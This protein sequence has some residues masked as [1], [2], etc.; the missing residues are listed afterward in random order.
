[1]NTTAGENPKYIAKT[2]VSWA[3]DNR[4]MARKFGFSREV[5]EAQAKAYL[6]AARLIMKVSMAA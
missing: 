1:M 4:R 6:H 2:L 5:L 3:I